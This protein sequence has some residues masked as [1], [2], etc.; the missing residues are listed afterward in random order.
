MS[1]DDYDYGEEDFELAESEDKRLS[2]SELSAKKKNVTVQ[3]H[4]KVNKSVESIPS[5][6]K[7][8]YNPNQ[9][10]DDD[11]DMLDGMDLEKYIMEMK[12]SVPQ[13]DDDTNMN[14]IDVN[15][16]MASLDGLTPAK[17]DL[18][19]KI[20][21]DKYSHNDMEVNHTPK[22][23]IP[24][25]IFLKPDVDSLPIL[26]GNIA[27][28]VKKT[29]LSPR[30]NGNN[31]VHNSGNLRSP[32]ASN[33]KVSTHQQVRVSSAK[34]SVKSS[35][36]STT[37][38][39]P[40]QHNVSAPSSTNNSTTN[41]SKYNS[42]KSNIGKHHQHDVDD[43][44]ED[45]EGDDEDDDDTDVHDSAA[46]A[47]AFTAATTSIN[48]KKALQKAEEATETQEEK[49]SKVDALLMEL[50][51]ERY[52]GGNNYLNNLLGNNN[53]QVSSA[54]HKKKK[55]KKNSKVKKKKEEEPNVCGEYFF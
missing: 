4:Q 23:G 15:K 25:N 17:N 7:Q 28:P 43:D 9:D 44:D 46:A 2:I 29:M 21:F 10:D 53:P 20:A 41:N 27:T 36:K 48:S 11:E 22:R 3:S 13:P 51:P 6:S 1:D 35:T 14:N 49:A 26:L 47:A 16:V 34:S 42:P 33:I 18:D 19:H 24:F 54:G 40:I 52:G 32:V 31:S 12:I 8:Q 50:F 39:S 45:E 37:S 30:L 55:L 5:D 38:F